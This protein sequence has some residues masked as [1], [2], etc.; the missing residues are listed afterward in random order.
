MAASFVL[1]CGWIASCSD[2][3]ET[4]S[5]TLHVQALLH[6]VRPTADGSK[7]FNAPLDG[8]SVRAMRADGLR[9]ESPIDHDGNAV[10]HLVPGTY[11]ISTSLAN[12][13]VTT[14]VVVADGQASNLKLNCVAP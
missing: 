9:V 5:A 6:S 13:C 3:R 2:H 14:K 4:T 10:L 8:Y 12:A 11:S 7:T 1:A